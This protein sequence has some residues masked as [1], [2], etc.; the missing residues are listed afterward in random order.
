MTAEVTDARVKPVMDTI[1][2]ITQM[3]SP[4][5]PRISI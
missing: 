1:W 3:T 2:I 5:L 4:R